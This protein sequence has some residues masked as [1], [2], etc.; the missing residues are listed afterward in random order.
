MGEEHFKPSHG[1]LRLLF[2]HIN[3]D[4]PNIYSSCASKP[5]VKEHMLN[6]SGKTSGL[7]IELLARTN[8]WKPNLSYYLVYDIYCPKR[9]EKQNI[10]SGDQADQRTLSCWSSSESGEKQAEMRA[11]PGPNAVGCSTSVDV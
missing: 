4:Q 2:A 5:V 3:W 8:I 10:Y 11:V 9:R 7:A 6:S 1:A